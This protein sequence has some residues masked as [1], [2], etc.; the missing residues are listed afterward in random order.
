VKTGPFRASELFGLLE[1]VRRHTRFKPLVVGGAEGRA[2]A[3][4]AGVIWIDW[5]DFL[6]GGVASPAP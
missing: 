1:F 4:R 6:V 3:E 5:R 2:P